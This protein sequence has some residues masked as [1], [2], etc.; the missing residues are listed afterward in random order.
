[1]KKLL[2]KEFESTNS[3]VD[4]KIGK[5]RFS[6]SHCPPHQG[7]NATRKSAKYGVKKPKYKTQKRSRE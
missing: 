2:E 1:M 6:C 7:E 5:F 4:K 3:S